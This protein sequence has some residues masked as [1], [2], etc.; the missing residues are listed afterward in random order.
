MTTSTTDAGTVARDLGPLVALGM[1]EDRVSL[2]DG[3]V[4]PDGL[5]DYRFRV[6]VAGD[7]SAMVLAATDAQGHP[8]GGELWDTIRGDPHSSE[9]ATARGDRGA[10]P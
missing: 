9:R 10:D 6:R 2:G 3:P 8:T 5:P 4:A 7:A 1:G